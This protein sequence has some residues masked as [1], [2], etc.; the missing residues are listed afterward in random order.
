MPGQDCSARRAGTKVPTGGHRPLA[1]ITTGRMKSI[2]NQPPAPRGKAPLA[3]IPLP[4]ARLGAWLRGWA[5]VARG[6]APAWLSCWLAWLLWCWQG[7]L[8][9]TLADAVAAALLLVAFRCWGSLVF[10]LGGWPARWS[11][12]LPGRLLAGVT[13]VSLLAWAAR[14]GLGFSPGQTLAGLLLGGLVGLWWL[15]RRGALGAGAIDARQ[16]R[17]DRWAI[18]LGLAAAT[19][20]VQA[21]FPYRFASADREVFTGLRDYFFHA[22]LIWLLGS[23]AD[24]QYLGRPGLAAEPLPV[25]HYAGYSAAALFHRYSGRPALDCAFLIWYPWGCALLAWSAYVLGDAWAG[26]RAGLASLILVAVVPDPSYWTFGLWPPGSFLY[27]AQRFV[28]CGPS[29]AYGIAVATL[30]LAWLSDRSASSRSSAVALATVALSIWF[31]AQVFLIVLPVAVLLVV[32]NWLWSRGGARYRLSPAWLFVGAAVVVLAFFARSNTPVVQLE[33]PPGTRYAAFLFNRAQENPIGRQLAVWALDSP[34]ALAVL[35]RAALCLYLPWRWL[36]LVIPA[37]FWYRRRQW[38]WPELTVALTLAIYLAY[39]LLLAPNRPDYEFGWSW[40]FQHVPFAWAYLVVMAWLGCQVQ[41]G[42]DRLGVTARGCRLLAGAVLLWAAW[43]GLA[44][45]NLGT[46]AEDRWIRLPV[47]GDLVRCAEFLR[48]QTAP[49]D[50]F[51]DSRDDP[52]FIVETLAE[53][54]AWVGWTV[55]ATYSAHT[56][57]DAVFRRRLREHEQLRQLNDEQAI[58]RWAAERRVKWY[59]RNPETPLAWPKALL[60]RPAFVAGEYQVYDLDQEG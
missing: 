8:R 58:Y 28:F 52:Y 41:C 16:R 26:P 20:Q 11:E 31:K 24:S 48:F 29:N 35:A 34:P 43:I 5:E 38:G 57:A 14:M 19:V 12:S 53:R 56:P 3:A 6:D 50:R 44:P 47:P 22:D 9:L 1:T 32:A 10:A 49:A 37:V 36:V 45:L 18:I 54:R 17:A 7:S 13:A 46:L 23:E 60:D 33:W 42:L 39:A 55:T 25:Y 4:A 40:N 51:Q 21:A 2:G 59:L 30:G 15:A 27:S